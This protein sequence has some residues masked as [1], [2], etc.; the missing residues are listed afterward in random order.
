M[1]L[2]WGMSL[3][4]VC[5]IILT[6]CENWGGDAVSPALKCGADR[7][8]PCRTS[9]RALAEKPIQFDGKLVRVEGYLSLAREL[10]LLSSSR[11]LLEAGVTDEVSVRIR[12]PINTQRDIFEKHAYTWVSVVGTFRVKG[13]G[14]TTDDL[15]IGEIHAP[16]DVQSLRPIGPLKRAS[17]SEVAVDLEDL[18]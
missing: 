17:F 8:L 2:I 1:K 9:F 18:N 4:F 15:L 10:F 13:K 11:E 14:G 6:G 16:L 12:G 3:V 5:L 7:Q